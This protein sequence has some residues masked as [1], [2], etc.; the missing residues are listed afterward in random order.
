MLLTCGSAIP[1]GSVEAVRGWIGAGR[2]TDVRFP[3]V[4][5][6]R[7]CST[8]TRLS[9]ENGNLQDRG[10]KSSRQ[11]ISHISRAASD[12][13]LAQDLNFSGAGGLSLPAPTLSSP[14]LLEET[15]QKPPQRHTAEQEPSVPAPAHVYGSVSLSLG[16]CLMLCHFICPDVPF[17][18]W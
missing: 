6:A 15:S 13:H 5:M 17:C 7:A 4:V 14:L 11:T 16:C 1:E 10:N 18:K 2:G 8:S 12:V 9:G 3:A